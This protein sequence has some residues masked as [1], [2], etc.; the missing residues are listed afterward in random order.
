MGGPG[1]VR[2]WKGEGVR[3]CFVTTLGEGAERRRGEPHWRE[4]R[5]TDRGFSIYLTIC[6]NL[7]QYFECK[8]VIFSVFYFTPD[9]IYKEK[10][11]FI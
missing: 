8:A 5:A 1:T 6:T 11:V 4:P 3:D 10:N 2:K 9:S 7:L